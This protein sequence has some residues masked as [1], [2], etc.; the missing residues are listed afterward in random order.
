MWERLVVDALIGESE[1]YIYEQ[2]LCQFSFSFS[3][4]DQLT[5]F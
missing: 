1:G 3:I 5:L 2:M 4:H